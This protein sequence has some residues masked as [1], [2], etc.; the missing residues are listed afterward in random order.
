VFF[1]A[2]FEQQGHLVGIGFKTRIGSGDIVGN[3]YVRYVKQKYGL[4]R[5]MTRNLGRIDNVV[6]LLKL[7]LILLFV[8]LQETK[9]PHQLIKLLSYASRTKVKPLDER[10]FIYYLLSDA[11]SELL[12]KLTHYLRMHLTQTSSPDAHQLELF[13]FTRG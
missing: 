7:V 3:D 10:R 11:L 1:C 13:D 12:I 5:F 6:Y 9:S 2:I 8:V 4:E